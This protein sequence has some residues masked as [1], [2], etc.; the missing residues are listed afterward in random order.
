MAYLATEESTGAKL[1]LRVTDSALSREHSGAEWA[2]DEIDSVSVMPQPGKTSRACLIVA[3][4]EG[5]FVALWSATTAANVLAEE[6]R[7]RLPDRGHAEGWWNALPED[8]L[9]TLSGRL[10]VSPGGAYANG[11]AMVAAVLPA[12]ATVFVPKWPRQ[13]IRWELVSDVRVEGIDQ[14]RNR[15]PAIGTFLAVGVFALAGVRKEGEAYLTLTAADGPW[16]L[17]VRPYMPSQLRAA[18]T[19]VLNAFLPPPP[20]PLH[21]PPPDQAPSGVADRLRQLGA[22][23]DEGLISTGEFDS[24]KAEILREL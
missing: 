11:P 19:P 16:T 6:V 9:M 23:R 17:A 1:S 20:P 10:L 18:L 2:L 14:V 22:L 4:H 7:A 3:T 12:G 8:Y 24:R 5:P 21:A 13:T 15:Y